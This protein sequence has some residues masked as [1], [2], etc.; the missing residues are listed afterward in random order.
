[1]TAATFSSVMSRSVWFW[2]AAGVPWLSAKMSAILAPFSAGLPARQAAALGQRHD[3]RQVGVAVVDD[4]DA[5]FHRHPGIFAGARRVA[6][7]RVDGADL[8]GVLGAGCGRPSQNRQS[9]TR[10]DCPTRCLMHT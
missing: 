10:Y 3:L 7:Q 9:R 1:M 8:D 6:A 5:D 2:P 4:I